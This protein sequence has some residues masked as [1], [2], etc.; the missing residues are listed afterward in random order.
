MKITRRQ[1][2]KLIETTIKP[3]IPSIP[4]DEFYDK[5]D[6][7]ARGG[8]TRPM[9]DSMA[10]SFG[11]PEDR[12][13]SDD[14]QT[15]DQANMSTLETV[16]VYRHPNL[17]IAIPRELVDDVIDAHLAS[18]TGGFPGSAIFRQAALRVFHYIEDETKRIAGED[19]NVYEYGLAVRGYRSD[20]YQRAMMAV[21][22]YI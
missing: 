5:I 18:K 16:S 4:K 17:E 13:Y 19:K 10:S 15:Y 14:L 22:E 9:A 12:S 6:T 21:G 7:L 11:Y 20:E 3:S 2:R 8:D 1:L